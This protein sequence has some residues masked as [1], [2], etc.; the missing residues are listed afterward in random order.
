MIG[1][2]RGERDEAQDA[3]WHMYMCRTNQQSTALMEEL[4]SG[5]C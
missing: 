1:T 5:T 2:C 3:N 4:V